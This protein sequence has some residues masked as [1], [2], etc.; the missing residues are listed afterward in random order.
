VPI[1]DPRATSGT[2]SSASGPSARSSARGSARPAAAAARSASVAGE[3]ICGAAARTARA[4]I[5]SDASSGGKGAE[6]REQALARRV[7]VRA[8]RAPHAAR[9]RGVHEVDDAEVGERGDGHPRHGRERALVVERRRQGG[10]RLRQ[11]AR[12]LLG[13]AGVGDVGADADHALRVPVG[14][15]HQLPA[16]AQPPHLA[17]GADDAVRE[18]VRL[19]GERALD[20]A[21]H[22][23]AVLRVDVDLVRLEG[24][25]EGPRLQPVHALER[26][27]PA[28]PPVGE[29]PL[30]GAHA[31]RLERQAEAGL[32]RPE[33]LLG[34]DARGEVEVHEHHRR[35]RAG[36]VA[37]RVEV[38]LRPGGR[39]HPEVGRRLVAHRRQ[40]DRRAG[41][42]APDLVEQP[43]GGELRVLEDRV[44]ARKVRGPDAEQP[45]ERRVGGRD[46]SR[47][48]VHD[49]AQRR[50]REQRVREAVARHQRRGGGAAGGAGSDTATG[51]GGPRGGEPQANAS[52]I[53]APSRAAA[54]GV[55]A[56]GL[57]TT[58]SSCAAP[59]ARRTHRAR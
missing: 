54:A 36:R 32:A 34:P 53:V 1:T 14:V 41:E 29:H 27:R 22:R 40:R 49:G 17:V 56:S 57:A 19:P 15:A 5:P 23:V 42:G 24:P 3:R 55:H 48:V 47:R 37:Q 31:P 25:R 9:R 44:V 4:A 59:D 6:R 43:L 18:L 10:A 21:G 7:D 38:R 2:H 46:V 28:H 45:L 33:R 58:C 50:L 26:L 52:F 39:R 8:G 35:H 20:R 11:Q 16:R 13:A 12:P 51:R 30:P